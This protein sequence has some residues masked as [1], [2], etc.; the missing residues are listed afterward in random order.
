MRLIR[1]INP[2]GGIAD[3]WH[4]FRRPN[5]YKIPILLASF[6]IT[7]SLVGWVFWED[8]FVPPPPPQVT[9]IQTYPEGR[10]DAEIMA[11]NVANQQR[12]DRA[13]AEQE[14][15]EEAAR[16]AYRALGRATGLDVDAM[17][18]EARVEQARAEAAKTA[19]LERLTDGAVD[20]SAE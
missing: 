15:R 19:E 5:P 3:F 1:R 9:F 20:D 12:K 8:Y 17:E 7:G 4:E 14:K 13:A 10:S 2:T 11:S 16:D 6:A 18:A